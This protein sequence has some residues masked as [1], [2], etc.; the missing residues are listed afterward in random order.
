MP[1]LSI[2][3]RL[4]LLPLI[5][6]L[7]FAAVLVAGYSAQ[8]VV[9]RSVESGVQLRGDRDALTDAWFAV[10]DVRSTLIE[11]WALNDPAQAAAQLNIVQSNL[12]YI[13]SSVADTM[14]RAGRKRDFAAA[15][16]S[17]RSYVEA[18]LDERG[19]GHPLA[20]DQLIDGLKEPAATLNG[21]FQEQYHAV[22]Q[23]QEDADGAIRQ[24][25]RRLLVWLAGTAGGVLVLLMLAMA[26]VI[27][28]VIGPL[29]AIETAMLI[30]SGGDTA[31]EIPHTGRGDEIGSMSRAVLGFRESMLQVERLKE[32]RTALERQ[33]RRR[34]LQRAA[35]SFEAEGRRMLGNVQAALAEVNAV[36]MRLTDMAAATA[37]SCLTAAQ[38]AETASSTVRDVAGEADSLAEQAGEALSR[39]ADTARIA[40][41]AAEQVRATD[42]NIRG[43]SDAAGKIGDVVGLIL[44]IASRTRM[45]ALNATIEAARAGEMGKGFAVVAG[46]VK[47]L[48]DQ[49]TRA[50]QQITDQIKAVQDETRGAVEA[51]Q[52]I[53]GIILEIDRNVSGVAS[54]AEDQVGAG[55]RIKE[56]LRTAA[57]GSDAASR[58]IALV[59]DSARATDALAAKAV[60]AA[61]ILSDENAGLKEAIEGFLVASAREV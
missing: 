22:V 25:N 58:A 37:G 20:F 33:E 7:G 52:Q 4:W 38:G 42:R 8:R 59:S 6:A 43:L 61:E 11:A 47:S 54:I 60:S 48:A 50:T 9:E 2:R 32:E 3:L 27:R 17:F 14:E 39:V 13:Q 34:S 10:Q 49:T 57:H 18:R 5:V 12:D 24:A 30:L 45:L 23:Q 55:A 29:R 1:D 51:I 36:A 41:Q 53:S 31:A 35:G 21:I 16:A 19:Q 40:N 28:S 15:L 26:V 46:E 44:D 56:S